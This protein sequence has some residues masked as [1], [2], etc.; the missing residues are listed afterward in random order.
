MKV[1]A[2]KDFNKQLDKLPEVTPDIQDIGEFVLNFWAFIKAGLIV[3]MVF[4]NKEKDAKILAWIEKIEKYR[5]LVTDEPT[6]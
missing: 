1:Q 5:A 2:I 3:A 6:N 4:T